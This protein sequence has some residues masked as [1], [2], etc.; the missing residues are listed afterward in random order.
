MTL[1]ADEPTQSPAPLPRS[2]SSAVGGGGDT[3][4]P[5]PRQWW[6]AGELVIFRL[7]VLYA[8]WLGY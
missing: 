8:L 5:V 1:P 2:A 4:N 6:H 7:C 3:G